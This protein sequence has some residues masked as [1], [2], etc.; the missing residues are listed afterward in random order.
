M[1]NLLYRIFQ[2]L[3]SLVLSPSAS[4]INMEF[5][6]SCSSAGALHVLH[7]FSGW[8]DGFFFW[9]RWNESWFEGVFKQLVQMSALTLDCGESMAVYW[10]DR[11][12]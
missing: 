10:R 8:S 12:C 6:T 7:H 11:I 5:A 3:Q 1:A 9:R 2:K 4:F